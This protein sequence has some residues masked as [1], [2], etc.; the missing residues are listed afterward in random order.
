V[1]S[2]LRQQGIVSFDFAIFKRTTFGPAERM[3]LELRTEFFNTSTIHSLVAPVTFLQSGSFGV[4]NNTLNNPRLVPVC[5][6]ICVSEGSVSRP[7]E[8]DAIRVLAP[9]RLGAASRRRV[10][11]QVGVCVASLFRKL[12][13]SNAQNRDLKNQCLRGSEAFHFWKVF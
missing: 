8:G 5:S 9:S 7:A 3:G 4:V 10:F 6:E 2:S 1:D 13:F 12:H 11:F